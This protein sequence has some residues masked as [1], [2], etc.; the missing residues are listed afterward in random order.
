MLDAERTHALHSLARQY[1]WQL[2]VLFGSSMRGEGRDIDIAVLPHRPPRGLELG[3][4]QSALEGALVPK[5][6][7]LVV[8]DELTPHVTRYE[9]FVRGRPVF[10]DRPGL[11][12][13]EYDRAFFVYADSEKFRQ[14]LR[15]YVKGTT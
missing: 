12:D 15:E 14:A 3:E 9:I 1:D 2:V 10:E 5:R 13:R 7:D 8:V 4:W 6:V 11:F